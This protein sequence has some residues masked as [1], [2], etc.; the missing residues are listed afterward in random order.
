MP[1]SLSGAG[2][3]AGRYRSFRRG[4]RC[5]AVSLA[6]LLLTGCHSGVLDPRGPVGRSERLILLDALAIMLVVIGPVILATLGFAWWFRASNRRARYRPQWA[7]SGRIEFIVWSIPVLIVMFLGGIAW[8]GSHDLDPYRSLPS[9]SPV[10]E[11]QVVSLDWKWLFIYPQEGVASVNRL[12]IPAGR[13]VHFDLTAGTVMNSFFVPQLGSQIYTMAGM[14]SQLSLQADEP[15][16]YHGLSAM[17]SGAGFPM[18]EFEVRALAGP[19]FA[20][21]VQQ[22]RG[23]GGLLDQAAGEG[24]LKAGTLP[25]P[26]SYGT[27]SPQIFQWLQTASTGGDHAMKPAAMQATLPPPMEH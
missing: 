7:Y 19:D 17:F 27:V 20:A 6:A 11:V 14:T 8:I 23:A 2:G 18:M 10:E 15:G 25:A 21:W 26:V 3:V 13:P 1:C 9:K 16:S 12:V 24:L 22:T 5:L 4:G